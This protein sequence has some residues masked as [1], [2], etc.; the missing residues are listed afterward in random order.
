MNPF[1]VLELEPAFEQLHLSELDMLLAENRNLRDQCGTLNAAAALAAQ[2]INDLEHIRITA[3]EWGAAALERET[4]SESNVM[5]FI[6][7]LSDSNVAKEAAARE[8]VTLQAE[9]QRLHARSEV[10]SPNPR[11]PG[12]DS[13]SWTK[14]TALE[15]ELEEVGQAL[16]CTRGT[17]AGLERMRQF[18]IDQAQATANEILQL[19]SD[20]AAARRAQP[21]CSSPVER[22]Q[23]T[24]VEHQQLLTRLEIARQAAISYTVT[25][26]VLETR[27]HD[28]VSQLA[29]SKALTEDLQQR[30]ETA[31][32]MAGVNR[33][34]LDQAK[35]A[36]AEVVRLRLKVN[37][38]MQSNSP[39]ESGVDDF[40]EDIRR[41]SETLGLGTAQAMQIQ[42]DLN[43]AKHA[44]PV[45]QQ[46]IDDLQRI[47]FSQTKLAEVATAEYAQ[48]SYAALANKHAASELSLLEKL[49]RFVAEMRAD[50][51]RG[52][53]Q[54]GLAA[55]QNKFPDVVNG[56][57]TAEDQL[58]ATAAT[59]T[60]LPTS[61]TTSGSLA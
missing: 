17:I 1:N 61:A 40:E 30:L 8:I 45:S 29:S 34:I 42:S 22:T 33:D 54:R 60:I 58:V 44:A 28:L 52:L 12:S 19:R 43:A 13:G 32:N 11:D 18:S 26:S 21:D 4:A 57:S 25:I 35:T 7:E 46:R 48:A 27:H 14:I 5:Y 47:N 55:S 9:V 10:L 50:I 36:A 53:M 31:I 37:A 20:L 39:D 24:S 38:L 41:S 15:E 16:S 51:A 2:Q 59:A 49:E 23:A 56:D 3:A 6:G